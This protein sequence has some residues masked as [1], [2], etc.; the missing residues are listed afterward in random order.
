VNWRES[1]PGLSISK[2]TVTLGEVIHELTWECRGLTHHDDASTDADLPARLSRSGTEDMFRRPVLGRQHQQS[3]ERAGRHQ[4]PAPNQNG[5][6]A[7]TMPRACNLR[8]DSR[9]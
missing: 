9:A 7:G 5:W 3:Q 1:G 8:F 2:V 6:I 4:A